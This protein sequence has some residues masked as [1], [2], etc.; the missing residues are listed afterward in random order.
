MSLKSPFSG[1]SLTTPP[2][3]PSSASSLLPAVD[4]SP[5]DRRKHESLKRDY[6]EKRKR[7]KKLKL[8]FLPRLLRC[9]IKERGD[10][11]AVK[12][13]SEGEQ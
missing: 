2:L 11:E 12:A 10:S 9:V 3:S 5:G 8:S 1:P 7:R 13:Q 4:A 6:E